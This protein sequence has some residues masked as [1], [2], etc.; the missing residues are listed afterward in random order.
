MP[1][2]PWHALNTDATLAA[3]ASAPDGLSASEAS[4][5]LGRDGPNALSERRGASWVR[6]LAERSCKVSCV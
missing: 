1:L 5:R 4:Q 2:D 3:V 6:K